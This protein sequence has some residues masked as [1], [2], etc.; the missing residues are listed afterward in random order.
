MSRNSANPKSKKRKA[1]D[2][3]ATSALDKKAKYSKEERKILKTAALLKAPVTAA[4][5]TDDETAK[6]SPETSAEAQ[7]AID[8]CPMN[9]QHGAHVYVV[10]PKNGVSENVSETAGYL[11]VT[12]PVAGLYDI[13]AAAGE[14]LRDLEDYSTVSL[15]PRIRLKANSALGNFQHSAPTTSKFHLKVKL[16]SF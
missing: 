4:D 13:I 11:G 12:G 16:A 10:R 15:N 7:A 2:A 14:P 9:S 3:T 5:S 6:Q 8:A 1:E